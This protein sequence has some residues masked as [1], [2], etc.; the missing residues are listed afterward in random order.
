MHSTPLLHFWIYRKGGFWKNLRGD[1]LNPFCH[2]WCV[3]LSTTATAAFFLIAGLTLCI[4]FLA[5]SM[6]ISHPADVPFRCLSSSSYP[7][8]SHLFPFI[9]ALWPPTPLITVCLLLSLLL[10]ILLLS[11]PLSILPCHACS[12]PLPMAFQRK[13]NIGL[14]G[15]S[16]NSIPLPALFAPQH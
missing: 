10:H 9:W 4:S 8:L 1:F 2:A 5:L 7:F 15:V 3:R 11:T 12:M 14:F 6:S 16:K 13:F